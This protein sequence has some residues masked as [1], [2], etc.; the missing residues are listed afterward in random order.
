LISSGILK[1]K[2][3]TAYKG[4][5]DDIR[6]AGATYVDSPV[7]VSDNIITSPHY[8]NNPEFMAK[9]IEQYFLKNAVIH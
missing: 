8:N 5:R 1:H 2:T 4:I 6:N 9:V 7:V 3:A